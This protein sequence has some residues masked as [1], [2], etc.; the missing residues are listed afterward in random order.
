MAPLSLS[1]YCP[2]KK[3]HLQL[4]VTQGSWWGLEGGRGGV[5][6]LVLPSFLAGRDVSVCIYKPPSGG[7]IDG[8]AFRSLTAA[9][10]SCC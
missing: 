1:D 3:S 2:L 5:Q 7:T 10:T 9:V 6:H 8:L 4:Q